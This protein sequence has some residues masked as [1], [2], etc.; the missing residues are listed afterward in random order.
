MRILKNKA[1]WFTIYGILITLI[2]IYLLFPSDIARSRIEAA[3]NSAGFTLK[4]DS[5]R[6]AIPFGLKMKNLTLS[7]GSSSIIYFQGDS[8]DLQ[9]NPVSFFQK[10]KYINLN[11]KAYGGNFS[12]SLGMA[13]FSKVYPPEEGILKIKNIDLGKYDFIKQLMGREVTGKASGSWIFNKSTDRYFSGK[14][15]LFLSKGTFAL[16]EPLLGLS[17]ID[18]NR[19][20]IKAIIK[21]GRLIL[22]KI[23]IFGPQL[24]CFLN[25]D[26][27]LAED[28]KNSQINLSGEMVVTEKKVKMK[29]NIGGTLANPLIRYI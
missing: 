10:D 24:D 14:I 18:Y 23:E 6:A 11:G 25:G 29:I 27:T 13:S 20:E 17:R 28:F 4:T 3:L 7:S 5:L 21:N 22:E 12:G 19:G 16:S 15:D 26:L 8:L 1:L 9:F 2:F